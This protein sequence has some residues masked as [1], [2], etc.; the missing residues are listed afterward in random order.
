MNVPIGV[1]II[2]IIVFAVF[3][4]WCTVSA[5]IGFR[6]VDVLEKIERRMRDK[7]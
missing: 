5:A 1:Q 2:A 4:M 3:V 7:P 6:I